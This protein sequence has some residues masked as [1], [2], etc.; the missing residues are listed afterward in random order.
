VLSARKD[1]IGVKIMVIE[2][3]ITGLKQKATDDIGVKTMVS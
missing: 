1:D 3:V 2:P